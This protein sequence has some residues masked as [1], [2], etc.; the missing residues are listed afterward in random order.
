MLV[1]GGNSEKFFKN[2]LFVRFLYSYSIVFYLNN[3]VFSIAMY[4]NVYYRLSMLVD[5]VLKLS[6]FEKEQ[7]E[8]KQDEFDIYQLTTEVINSMSLQFEKA[9]AKVFLHT[10]GD[11]FT[12][13]ADQLHITSVLYNLIDN[14]LKYGK[15]Q[16]VIDINIHCATASAPSISS[17]TS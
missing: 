17:N 7:T 3:A 6:M 15:D 8:L 16:P 9:K 12:I 1:I 13:H 14:A 4:V 11:S 5:K 10:Q 2:L